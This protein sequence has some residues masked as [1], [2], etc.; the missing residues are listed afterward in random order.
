MKNL[1]SLTRKTIIYLGLIAVIALSVV[2]VLNTYLKQKMVLNEMTLASQIEKIGEL[3]TTK[4]RFQKVLNPSV[5]HTFFGLFDIP[6]VDSKALIAI[7]AEASGCIDLTQVKQG[8]ILVGAKTVE[9]TL[10]QPKVC[11][12]KI[13]HQNM[14]T[15]DESLTAKIFNPELKDDAI[16]LAEQ[17]IAKE[18]VDLGILDNTKEQAT[19]LISNLLMAATGKEIKISYR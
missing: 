3:H 2:I 18:A 10:P 13:D 8:D 19:A 4:I 15:Y 11:Q 1:F 17:N 9:I 7:Q 12:V 5:R 14:I 16:K 6:F